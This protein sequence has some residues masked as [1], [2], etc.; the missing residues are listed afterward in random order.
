M[1]REDVL[2]IF[3]EGIVSINSG[4][5]ASFSWNSHIEGTEMG[6][7]NVAGFRGLPLSQKER[8]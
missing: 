2:I 5:N 8:S 3:L 4:E 1:K 7:L 6:D